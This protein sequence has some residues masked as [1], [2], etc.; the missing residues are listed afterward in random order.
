MK[1]G[2]R[3]SR[4]LNEVF[5]KATISVSAGP[6][7][8]PEKPS[9]RSLKLSTANIGALAPHIG[10][11][12]IKRNLLLEIKT[13][14]QKQIDA[15]T[16][17]CHKEIVDLNQVSDSTKESTNSRKEDEIPVQEKSAESDR[18]TE[19]IVASFPPVVTPSPTTTVDDNTNKR[20]SICSLSSGV[21]L[22]KRYSPVYERTRK[23]IVR[24]SSSSINRLSS[25]QP[26]VEALQQQPKQRRS[27]GPSSP[28]VSVDTNGTVAVLSPVASK[29]DLEDSE[30]VTDKMTEESLTKTV[31][32]VPEQFVDV[33]TSSSGK[34]GGYSAHPSVYVIE[35]DRRIGG[36]T[37][38][39]TSRSDKMDSSTNTL[40]RR[41]SLKGLR[42]NIRKVSELD[43]SEILQS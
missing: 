21:E 27:A 5:P 18:E 38:L 29:G 1:L 31:R 19:S 43:N 2:H 7:A 25:S 39:S 11:E 4:S 30:T 16:T 42:K 33:N 6:P 8:V 34:L 40:K 41:P 36:S 20:F 32:D 24:Q 17:E 15:K 35:Q 37:G 3:R 12:E 13:K 9:A 22:R 10:L 28:A 14:L 23:I 26:Q